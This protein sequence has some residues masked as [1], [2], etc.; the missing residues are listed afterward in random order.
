MYVLQSKLCKLGT[1]YVTE[2]MSK[3][4]QTWWTIST[5]AVIDSEQIK[6]ETEQSS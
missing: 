2:I 6:T 4:S 3:N 5:F 1:N